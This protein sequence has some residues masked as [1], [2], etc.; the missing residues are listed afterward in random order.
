MRLSEV[1][2]VTTQQDSNLGV[3]H[4]DSRT[5]LKVLEAHF[6]PFASSMCLHVFLM[7]SRFEL[8]IVTVG[9]VWC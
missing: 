3:R 8:F 9:H 2:A 7:L 1:M 5:E 6:G 4:L